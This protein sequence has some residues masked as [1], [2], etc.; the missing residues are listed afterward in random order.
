MDRSIFLE[1]SL[2]RLKLK[3]FSE[4]QR[5]GFDFII[6][7]AKGRG[8]PLVHL[9]YM[10]A[11]TWHE[12]AAT[13]QPVLETKA[14]NVEEAI[15]RLDRAFAKGQLTWVKTPY[16]RKDADGKSWLGRGYVQLTHKANYQK[17][18][19][20]I[21]G[22][23]LVA[24]PDRAM[25]PD[26]AVEIL[27][28]GMQLGSFTGKGLSDYLDGVTP[29][30]RLARRIINGNESAAL[31]AGYAQAF[32][33]ALRAAGYPH[34]IAGKAPE[35]IAPKPAPVPAREPVWAM[36]APELPA[37]IERKPAQAN[38]LEQLLTALTKIFTRG[39]S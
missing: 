20:L 19:L 3:R 18:E 13:M 17:M 28:T 27:I 23:R 7:T 14:G 21:P 25:L 8:V 10:L 36:P 31:V 5:Q 29:N 4:T 39:K 26:V 22:S 37:A 35:P 33:H 38:W 11:T 15:R 34:V 24:D 32:E 6:A 12:T 2:R 9:A 30:Y 16:W 1:E